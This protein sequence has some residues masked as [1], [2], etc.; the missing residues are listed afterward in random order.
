MQ[1]SAICSCL[2][3]AFVLFSCGENKKDKSYQTFNE[4]VILSVNSIE[5]QGKDNPKSRH[6]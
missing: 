6:S 3:M 1:F 2:C 5:E 4:G